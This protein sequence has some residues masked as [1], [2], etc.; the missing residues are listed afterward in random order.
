MRKKEQLLWDAMKRAL[1]PRLRLQRVENLVGEGMPD[2]Y[3]GL[4]GKWVELKAVDKVPKRPDTPLL[5]DKTGL[6]LSQVNWHL[7][8]ADGYAPASY[9]L[10][11]I[12][13]EDEDN[14][15]AATVY[16]LPGSLAA[17]INAMPMKEIRAAS[18]TESWQGI[19][20]KLS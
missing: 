6:R 3:V 5:G 2:V 20:E 1:S 12:R 8:H 11:R 10:I 19:Q 7:A 15:S 16:L 14:L 18:L 4:S 17:R 13:G 9:V